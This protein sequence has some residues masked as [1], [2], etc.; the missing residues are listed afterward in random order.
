[1]FF[2]D[3]NAVIVKPTAVFLD[4]LLKTADSLPDLTLEQIRSN[5]NTYL[6][7]QCETPE[8]TA[9]YF[10]AYWLN[11]FRAELAS[12][13]IPENQWPPITPTEFARFFDLEFHDTVIDLDD[14]EL[15]VSPLIDNMM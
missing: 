9:G 10:S 8:E 15:Q 2:V 1:M 3:R 12:W 7:P 4:W 13:E 5:C 14:N 11:I 6:V